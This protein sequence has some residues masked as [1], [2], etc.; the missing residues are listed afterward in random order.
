MFYVHKKVMLFLPP[1]PLEKG[2]SLLYE[3]PCLRRKVV[4]IAERSS[5]F[6][7]KDVH[8]LDMHALCVPYI[9]VDIWAGC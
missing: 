3:V 4:Y 8:R 2:R 9:S 5:L 1:Y 7:A 6:F